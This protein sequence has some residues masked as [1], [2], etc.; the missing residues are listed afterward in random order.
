MR[1]RVNNMLIAIKAS[2]FP[3]STNMEEVFI[4]TEYVVSIA[5]MGYNKNCQLVLVAGETYYIT[6]EC[7][8]EL[9]NIMVNNG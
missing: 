5:K 7:A 6:Q 8:L 2:L 1:M 3:A 9:R 4:N